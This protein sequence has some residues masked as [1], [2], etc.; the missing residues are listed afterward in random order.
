MTCEC[1]DASHTRTLSNYVKDENNFEKP[2]CQYLCSCEW[3][4]LCSRHRE[5]LVV[6]VEEY[7]K[8]KELLQYTVYQ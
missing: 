6:S 3:L 5:R 4:V 7:K 8:Q 2:I 1:F